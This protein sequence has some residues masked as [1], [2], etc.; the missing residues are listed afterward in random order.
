MHNGLVDSTRRPEP[1]LVER[2]FRAAPVPLGLLGLDGRFLM[3]NEAAATLLRRDTDELVGVPMPTLSPLNDQAWTTEYLRRMATGELGEFTALRPV[4]LPDGS[5]EDHRL[6]IAPI[7]DDGVPI[8]LIATMFP[9]REHQHVTDARLSKLIENI[10]N[11]ISLIDGDGAL[12]ETS[13]NYKEILGYPSQFWAE[14]TIFDLLHPDDAMRVLAMR[15]SVLD[16][17]GHLVTG[18][19]SVKAADGTY[20]PLE[21]HAVN[22]L[23]DP[24][25]RGIVITSR[26]VSE[27]RQL[28]NEL[29]ESRDDAVAAAQ[30]RSRM[31]ATVSHELRNPLHAMGGLA[32]LLATSGRLDSDSLALTETLRRQI[33]AL[34]HVV[35]DLLDESRLS[36]GSLAL[37]SQPMAL[38][39]FVDDVVSLAQL[40]VKGKDVQVSAELAD[41]LPPAVMA[42]ASRLRQ[43]IGNLVGNAVKFTD[44]GSVTLKVAAEG[45]QLR[46]DIVDSG[47]GIA[48][49]ELASVFEPFST[50]TNA[51]TGSG[52]GLG[53]AIV[54]QLV[55]LMQGTVQAASSL[56][57][58][59][60]FTVRLPMIAVA[61]P[62][63]EPDDDFVP[64]RGA[65]VLVVEDNAVNQL[66]AKS[67]LTRLGMQAVIVGSGEAALELLAKGDGPT[68]VLMDHQLPGIDGLET[69]RRLRQME[70]G[71][72]R[73]AVVI[74]MT[75]SATLA[76]RAACEAAGM[77]DF[78]AKPV[79]LNTLNDTL[80]RW[81]R[82]ERRSRPRR[83]DDAGGAGDID[84][85][86][87]A[88]L[89][90][91]LGDA[92]VVA[93]LVRTFLAELRGRRTALTDAAT[94]GDLDAARRVAHTLKSS[95][96]LLGAAELGGACAR[97]ASIDD[98]AAMRTLVE[99]ILGLCTGAA[100][101]MQSWLID[102][103]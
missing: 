43:V 89:V 58:G 9:S 59:S 97:M 69:T 62:A 77:D 1:G 101:Q 32:E 79:G 92:D 102:H 20:Q 96:L 65:R 75:A 61:A 95:S 100:R 103:A 94:E 80:T 53:L 38:V 93:E 8:A 40:G 46:F 64:A 67:Q 87:L 66:L 48:E 49:S 74:S 50:A 17:P 31:V 30:L 78:M 15:Q 4:R 56:G 29:A 44:A 3:V 55:V 99:E 5:R 83:T 22:L 11:T 68:I 88:T 36:M 47:R 70:E 13:G 84:R 45:A 33:D 14:R 41:G 81:L 39:P 86:A 57:V 72:G 90:D 26:N 21:V 98:A 63:H 2:A 52:A 10:D 18:E 23:D 7:L 6:R 12:I 73:R 71:T 91:E 82:A 85:A 34:Q 76:D 35:D 25:V 28:L 42:D 37:R 51:G 54:R 60:T 24:D 27:Q 16:Q 19:F